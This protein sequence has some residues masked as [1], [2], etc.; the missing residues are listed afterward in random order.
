M[1]D[2]ASRLGRSPAQ[3]LLRWALQREVGVLPKARSQ[4][5]ID[6]N[7]ALNFEI[8][9]EDMQLLDELRDTSGMKYAWNPDAVV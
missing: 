2:V 1:A 9:L 7:I 3:V 8:P 4:D 6:E 5:R